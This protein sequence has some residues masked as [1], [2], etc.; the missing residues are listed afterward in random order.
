MNADFIKNILKRAN[1]KDNI[2]ANKVG[3]N[4]STVNSW[5]NGRSEPH[6]HNQ[7]VIRVVFKKEIQEMKEAGEIL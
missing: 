7:K 6:F 2:F 1:I 3:V 5:K 4:R